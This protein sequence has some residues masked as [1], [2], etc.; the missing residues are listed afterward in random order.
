MNLL[1]KAMLLVAAMALAACNNP[2]PGGTGDGIGGA[3]VG[4][5]TM[6][7]LGDPRDPTSRAYFAQTIGDRVF[8][9]TDQAT[10]SPTARATLDA[11]ARWLRDNPRFAIVVEGHA[12]ERGTREYN[13][14]LG[15]R[16]ANA[17]F[18]YLVAQGIPASRIR[19]I[20][21]GK[22]RPVEACPEARC[23]DLNRR[24]VTVLTLGATPGV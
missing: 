15:A 20:S 12:D 5:I 24:S 4:G 8:F 2:R 23:W 6:G 22:E 9:S 7:E 17:V 1:P 3:G 16:R 11:Q 10:L 21:Y 19:T 14:A 13:I 18:E